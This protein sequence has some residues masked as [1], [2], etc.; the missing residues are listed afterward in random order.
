MTDNVIMCS[1]YPCRSIGLY[2]LT[3]QQWSREETGL[4]PNISATFTWHGKCHFLV[5]WGLT[6]Q[7]LL[8][9][10]QNQLKQVQN[11]DF[12]DFFKRDHSNEFTKLKSFPWPFRTYRQIE[13]LRLT[14]IEKADEKIPPP[15]TIPL[16]RERHNLVSF[17]FKHI[18]TEVASYVLT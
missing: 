18:F 11:G 15:Q 6:S 16:F 5:S 12:F 4:L 13:L 9:I 14:V 3:K 1:G 10:T 17:V 7:L 8:D 2:D